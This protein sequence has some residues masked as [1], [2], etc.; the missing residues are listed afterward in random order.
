VCVCSVS[1]LDSNLGPHCPTADTNQA[2]TKS[3]SK[4]KGSDEDGAAAE[5]CPR[6]SLDAEDDDVKSNVWSMNSDSQTFDTSQC[7]SHS[8]TTH[9]EI[10]S[11]VNE[12]LASISHESMEQSSPGSLE[13]ANLETV[14]SGGPPEHANAESLSNEPEKQHGGLMEQSSV[15]ALAP[16]EL[17][18]DVPSD[19]VECSSIDSDGP[20][21]QQEFL[22]E[23]SNVGIQEPAQL[24]A[25]VVF[26]PVERASIDSISNEPAEQQSNANCESAEQIAK[27]EPVN[28][29]F[30][31]CEKSSADNS[32]GKRVIAETAYETPFSDACESSKR[33]KSCVDDS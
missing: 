24:E 31:N 10:E 8:D 19:T 22:I 32:L 18:V 28:D 13:P 26:D 5:G 23:Q 2:M 27:C 11:T 30:V 15:I 1:V 20:A 6:L 21:M 17:M 7:S 3:L 29:F 25:D 12:K 9:S 33:L 4:V 16:E 14:V